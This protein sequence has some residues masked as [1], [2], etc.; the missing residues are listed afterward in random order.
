MHVLSHLELLCQ[1]G[2]QLAADELLTG[3]LTML[4]SLAVCVALEAIMDS[5]QLT[6]VPAV[7]GVSTRENLCL[8]PAVCATQMKQKK[9]SPAFQHK[10]G[11]LVGPARHRCAERA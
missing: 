8:K 1:L 5:N 6:A 7:R 9:G 3:G 2:S 11:L 10:K 4:D